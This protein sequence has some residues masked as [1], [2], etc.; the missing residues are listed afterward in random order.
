MKV[1]LEKP[2]IIK[3]RGGGGRLSKNYLLK[4]RQKI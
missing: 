3:V 1:I 2:V 4:N